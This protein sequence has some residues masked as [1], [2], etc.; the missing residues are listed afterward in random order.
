MIT[1][2][3][4]FI[5]IQHTR[6]L[7]ARV[8][9][10]TSQTENVEIL[11]EKSAYLVDETPPP[12]GFS[13]YLYVQGRS[14]A[15]EG[16]MLKSPAALLPAS[17]G[18]LADGDLVS[19]RTNDGNIRVLYRKSSRHNSFLVTERCDNYCLMCSQP[20]RD[21]N[22]NWI[23]DEILES[24][25]MIDKETAELGFT[26]G[27]PTLLGEH[28]L[29]I[30]RTCAKDLPNTTIHVLSNGRKFSDPNFAR[31]WSKTGITD[32]MVGIPLYSDVSTIHDYVVQAD[33]AFDETV[34]GILNLKALRQRVE[35]RVVLHKQTYK[36]LARLAEFIARNLLFIDQV[37]LMG[38]EIMG[39]TRANLDV[40]WID[41]V[42][43]QDQL[44]RAVRTLDSAGMKVLIYNHQL[45]LLPRSLWPF[46]VKSISDWKNEYLEECESCTVRDQCGGFFHSA[47]YRRSANIRPILERG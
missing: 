21:I 27:E 9:R 46:A 26:G 12:N 31:A 38:L 5:P 29:E 3:G 22:D 13:A 33:G 25:P 11:P 23:A 4:R 43:Y 24:I 36:H 18:Y 42:E 1:L 10:V 7:R 37:A 30:L 39:F 40:L 8:L 41:P 47:K 17:F 16:E 35:L 19:F 20:P 28:F 45:C 6:S 34:R 14:A 15:A 2:G 44:D 32:L